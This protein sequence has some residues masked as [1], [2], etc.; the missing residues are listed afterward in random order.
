MSKSA[1]EVW[2]YAQKRN[3]NDK[4]FKELLIK[5]GIIIKK[6]ALGGLCKTHFNMNT[7]VKVKCHSKKE[8]MNYDS[9]KPVSTAIE[10]AVP[11]DQNSIFYQMS[12]GTTLVLNTVNQEAADMFQLGKDYDLVISPSVP[13]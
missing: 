8:I 5:E 6:P 9:N 7:I 2:K 4:E 10:L 12:G 11:Y 13:E 3:L 1:H